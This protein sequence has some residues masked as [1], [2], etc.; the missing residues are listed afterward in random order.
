M[1]RGRSRS[2]ELHGLLTDSSHVGGGPVPVRRA[3]PHCARTRSVSPSSVTRARRASQE[4]TPGRH[5]SIRS[6]Y[7]STPTAM[8]RWPP[9]VDRREARP[10]ADKPAAAFRACPTALDVSRG[11]PRYGVSVCT[12][13]SQV[14]TGALQLRTAGASPAMTSSVARVRSAALPAPHHG[15]ARRPRRL[16]SELEL[17]QNKGLAP[18]LPTLPYLAARHTAQDEAVE[19]YRPSGRGRRAWRP[20][21]GSRGALPERHPVP[22]DQLILDREVG[23]GECAREPRYHLLLQTIPSERLRD[24]DDVDDVAWREGGIRRGC[25][26]RFRPS[27]QMRWCSITDSTAILRLRVA[28]NG[29]REGVG[30]PQHGHQPTR[31]GQRSPRSGVG[32]GAVRG[33]KAATRWLD[34]DPVSVPSRRS[35]LCR[36]TEGSA[37]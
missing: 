5:A 3:N 11:R 20:G 9:P 7:P 33:A 31:G 32:R 14:C 12:G 21:L 29:D 25:T 27:A 10:K 26:P 6:A 18:L 37:T 8:C 35:S 30:K 16:S 28:V 2:H 22:V 19:R 23:V 13:T 15:G 1:W 4:F 36:N 34:S 24:T 17:L